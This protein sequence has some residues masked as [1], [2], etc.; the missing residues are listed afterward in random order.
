MSPNLWML[1]E[2]CSVAQAG[3][4]GVISA[5]CNLRL[6][7]SSDS[8][9]SA[10]RV[11]GTTGSHRNTQL[12]LVFLVEVAFCHIGQ[13]GLEL[14]TSDEVSPYWPG[15]SRTRDL[16]IHPPQPPKVWGLQHN[17]DY[18]CAPPCLA[19]CFVIFGEIGFHHVA[20]AGLEILS[21]SNWPTLA[22]QGFKPRDSQQRR[23]MGHQRDSFRRRGCFAGA[24]AR[25]FP[26]RSI[27]DRRARLV[28]SP[29][30]KQQ[31]EALRTESFIAS[32][33][34][35]GRSGSVGNGR[36]PKDN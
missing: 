23:H 35:P 25:R 36:L 16:I 22:S 18:S 33:A 8:P 5:H 3:G 15:W 32:T 7:G 6:L 9:A 12:I 13:A 26:V 28:P 24:P 14:L 19:N 27:R 34:N 10:S 2:S 1:S 21:S 20:Q 4:S 17:S 29:Q 31:L 30:G 11:A